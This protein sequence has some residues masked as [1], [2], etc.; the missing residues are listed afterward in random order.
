MIPPI[1]V[2]VWDKDGSLADGFSADDIL[3]SVKIDLQDKDYLLQRKN[4][5]VK[6]Y[7]HEIDLKRA[8]DE[9]NS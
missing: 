5:D 8:N 2:E 7:N 9:G 6:L 1:N 4:L 3:G